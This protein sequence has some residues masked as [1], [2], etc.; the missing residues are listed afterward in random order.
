M[1]VLAVFPKTPPTLVYSATIPSGTL[2]L[3]SFLKAQGHEVFLLDR[4]VNRKKLKKV[5]D[6]F[7]PEVV[8]ITLLSGLQIDDMIYVA[9]TA[10]EQGLP[11][12]CGGQMASAIPEQVLLT[13]FVDYVGFGEGEYTTLEL[14]E[15]LQG[16]RARESVKG[17]FY[18]DEQK[19]L[20]ETEFRPFADLSDFPKYDFSLL[21]NVASYY[22]SKPFASKIIRVCYA[23]GCPYNCAFCFNDRYY[24]R[25]YRRR[26]KELVLE[27]IRELVQEHGADGINFSDEI[28]GVDKEDLR[29]FCS[30]IKEQNLPYKWMCETRIGQLT[31]E[32]MK[33]MRDA[34]CREVFYGIESG[35]PEVLER[36]QKNYDIKRM[37]ET[38]E[39]MRQLDLITLA[40]II[41]GFPDETCG[42]LKQT[43]HAF[44]RVNPRY[45]LL[46]YYTVIPGTAL[47][48]QLVEHG[49]I[50]SSMNI[51]DYRF[52][53]G[54]E[55]NKF[56]NYSQIPTR[57]LRVVHAFF[58]WH[59][60]FNNKSQDKDAGIFKNIGAIVNHTLH[61]I[62][63]HSLLKALRTIWDGFAFVCTITYYSH[64]YPKIRKKYDLYAKNF[65]RQNWDDL[66][67]WGE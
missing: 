6:E 4:E 9:K 12:L 57:E 21:H 35:S 56:T 50:K 51:L 37:N 3:S 20:V 5:L 30:K 54:E 13:G 62:K 25:C 67:D 17:I 7:Q 18:L 26:P 60:V 42:Q 14:L 64:A 55:G 63:K 10:K 22:T 49:R 23:K 33:V 15:V 2:A 41:I 29:E 53:F 38:F 24:R 47:Q 16:K 19:R 59:M 65:G 11:V 61:N 1:R 52:A 39:N 31:R 27:E 58:N 36:I 28:W 43:V 34:G 44:F 32:D 8:C 45:T 46:T 48:Q 66:P 40:A